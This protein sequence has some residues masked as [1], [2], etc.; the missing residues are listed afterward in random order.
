MNTNDKFLEEHK[1]KDI[2]KRLQQIV[3]YTFITTPTLSEDD[4]TEETPQ[5]GNQENIQGSEGDNVENQPQQGQDE[6]EVSDVPE[7]GDMEQQ[8]MSNDEE[9]GEVE[10]SQ[11][12][13]GDEV[14]DVDDLTNSQK[15]T[16]YKIDGVDDK[17][18]RLAKVT[19]KLLTALE[20]NS[21]KIE[22]L[23]A[24]FEKRNPTEDEKLNLR[25]QA[26]YPYSVKPKDYWDNKSKDSNYDVMYNNQVDPDKE[27]KE[28]VLRKSDVINGMDDRSLSKSMYDFPHKI[29]D[30]FDLY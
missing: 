12:Q 9:N 13:D 5:Q 16:E 25:S 11:M 22:D 10:L 14:I 28:Y 1:L 4:D 27:D 30:Y 6:V 26:S 8:P 17:L 19:D 2:S 3:E 23:R 18:L 21:N 7:E 15:E 20:A 29:E 24:E